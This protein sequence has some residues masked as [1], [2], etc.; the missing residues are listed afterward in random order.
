ML[1]GSLDLADLVTYLLYIGLLV[2]P[3]GTALNFARL[4]QEG[5]TGF[6][7]FMEVLEVKPAIPERSRCD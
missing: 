7:R 6:D 1:A 3:V 5:V 4:Y 2:E